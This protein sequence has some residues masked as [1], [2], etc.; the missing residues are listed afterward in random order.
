MA[1]APGKAQTLSNIADVTK[2]IALEDKASFEFAQ[3]DWLEIP[4]LF[5]PV[6]CD[7]CDQ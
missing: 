5:R 3:S 6:T 7:E 1:L 4:L 2:S